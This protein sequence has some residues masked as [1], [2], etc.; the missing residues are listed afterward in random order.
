MS[1]AIER[2][3]FVGAGHMGGAMVRAMLRAGYDV[4]AYDLRPEALA[5]L[6]A[7]GAKAGKDPSEV[8][9]HAELLSVAIAGDERVEDALIGSGNLVDRLAPGA[10]IAIHSTV[11]PAVV[12]RVAERAAHGGI[13]II[14]ATVSGGRTAADAGTLCFMIGGDADVVTR[15]RPVFS[16]Y[17]SVFHMGP[18]GS[19]MVTKIAQQMMTTAN[20]VGVDEGTR[21]AEAAGVDL[22][23]FLT[24][25]SSTTGQSHVADGWLDGLKITGPDMAGSFYTSLNPAVELAGELGV[26]VPGTAL[27]QQLIR[28]IFKR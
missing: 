3:G 25:V 12:H 26:P 5:E 9:A 11:H 24:V 22:R 13:D 2:V 4:M 16:S 8:A 27:A 28:A 20:I 6:A 19:G 7:F 1:S 10:V 14:D 18:L 21:L 23:T 15:C 17:G